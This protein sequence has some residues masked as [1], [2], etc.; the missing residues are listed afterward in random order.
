[1]ELERG[2]EVRRPRPR[3]GGPPV[4]AERHVSLWIDDVPPVPR[5]PLQGDLRVDVAV[6][7]GGITGLTTAWLL[8]RKG[9][10]VAVLDM[11]RVAMRDSGH[12]TAH[13]TEFVD[14]HYGWLLRRYGIE[15]ARG[16]RASTR[17]A[18]ELIAGIADELGIDCHFQRIPM[19]YYTEVRRQLS[20][21]EAEYAAARR[22]GLKAV[23]VR[24]IPVP[25]STRGGIRID[26]Q[27]RFNPRRYLVPLAESLD[28][29]GVGIYEQTRVLQWTE[30]DPCLLRTSGGTVRAGRV[31]LATHSPAA[32]RGL[33]H[34]RI[35][36]YRT[37]VLGLRLEGG[38]GGVDDALFYDTADPYHY[39]R[40]EETASGPV[41]IVGGEDHKTG[42]GDPERSYERLE[43]W[44][45]AR[46]PVSEVAWRWSGQVYDPHEGIPYIG[47]HDRDGRVLFGTG[48]AGN[49]MTFGTVAAMVLA[50][51][52]L[53]R[54]NPWTRLYSP[55]RFKPLAGA[56]RYVQEN[57]DFPLHLLGDRFRPADAAALAD[58]PPGEGRL[59]DVGGRR[60]AAF[61]DSDGAVSTCS[62]TCP[63][64]GCHV[65][66][67]AAEKS[68]D[69][70]C[71]GSRFDARGG[72][73]NGPAAADL[74]RLRLA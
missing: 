55:S 39:V 51:R 4:G 7:G 24:A 22:I 58:V 73:L 72:L 5:P 43:T 61:R 65:Q 34:T 59:V 15:G 29:E 10:S 46:F 16:V 9:L 64:L 67:N 23:R 2:E 21:V 36:A 17:A 66:W 14:Y 56:T 6:V 18:I 20:Q 50:D 70:P 31:V 63:H 71:H 60:V 42:Q 13:L 48:Y 57:L 25:F 37:Y 1:M 40:F 45:R 11:A 35:A 49:G 68:W 41:L 26:D 12:T 53:G 28:R 52:I 33:I 27:A 62:A 30:G 19:Y 8:S 38:R 54:S 47:A 3:R 69:C 74:E 44:C 32:T